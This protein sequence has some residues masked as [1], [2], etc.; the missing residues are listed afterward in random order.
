MIEYV[1]WAFAGFVI[2]YVLRLQSE[3]SKRLEDIM[4]G[5]WCYDCK[6]YKQE[7]YKK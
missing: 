2:G 4:Y 5:R 3:Q 6:K 1:G 7:H